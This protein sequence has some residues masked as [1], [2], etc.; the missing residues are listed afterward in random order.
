ME[1]MAVLA[2]APVETL[3]PLQVFEMR[4][5]L[6]ERAELVL[7]TV[8]CPVAE[9]FAHTLTSR[10]LTEALRQVFAQGS[11][12]T[13]GFV[14]I[15]HDGRPCPDVLVLRESLDAYRLRGEYTV[16]DVLLVVEVSLTTQTTDYYAK[17]E[18]YARGG[19]PEY[20][21]VDL[22][23]DQIEVRTE[24]ESWGYG[25]RRVYHRGETVRG[26]SVD[27]ILGTPQTQES[28]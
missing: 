15:P 12:L 18:Q 16:E 17:D 4:E 11:V 27:A 5:D 25:R 26:L 19:I 3:T 2:S 28:A 1:D 7:G 23:A 10:W 20:W 22:A 6:D 9:S 21:I 14:P 24:P 13:E 8:L